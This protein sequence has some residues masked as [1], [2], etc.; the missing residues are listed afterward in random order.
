MSSQFTKA[1]QV[2]EL[3]IIGAGPAG[4]AA[5]KSAAP[6]LKQI[7]LIDN[8]P[9]AGGQYWRHLSEQWPSR[10]VAHFDLESGLTEISAVQ[11]L[12]NVQIWSDTQV[13]NAQYLYQSQY[14]N[15]LITL[16]IIQNGVEKTLLC[17]KLIVATGAYDRTLPFPGW[18]TPGV[19]TCGGAQALLKGQGVI[20]GKKI[21]VAG[22]GVFILPVASGLLRAGAKVI[23]VLEAN[24]GRIFNLRAIKLAVNFSKLKE[25]WSYLSSILR[26]GIKPKFREAVVAAHANSAG[27]LVSVTIAKLDRNWN[28]KKIRTV[29]CD[30]LAVGY[31]FTT[32]PGLIAALGVEMKVDIDTNVIVK[33][34]RNLQTSIPNIFAAG[35]LTGI[36]G[37]DLAQIEGRIAGLAAAG[38]NIPRSLR[39]KLRRALSFAKTLKK[40]YPIKNGWMNWADANTVICRC[41][42][43]TLSTLQYSVN[44]LGATDSRTAKLLS[45]CGMGLCQGR[46]CSRSVVDLVAAQLNQTPS[47]KDRIGT[48]KREVITPISLG[49]LAK[50]K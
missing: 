17:K 14:Q 34:N 20:A 41:E 33:V 28:I 32:D 27:E 2:E 13:W 24:S 43:V 5:A 46:I 48:A 7:I 22:S 12:A 23:E 45:R 15:G 30:L 47:D 39:R 18:D 8:N 21:V 26:A 25:A 38:A 42:E 19:M 6:Y 11:Q 9:N 16:R 29:E 49:V 40:F 1:E 10:D 31:G 4:L 50:D 3:V 37:K 44:E 35:E 36:G